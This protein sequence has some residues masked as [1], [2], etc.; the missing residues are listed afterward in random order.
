MKKLIPFDKGV[1]LKRVT[2]VKPKKKKVKDGKG[3]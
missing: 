1:L 3:N 2:A